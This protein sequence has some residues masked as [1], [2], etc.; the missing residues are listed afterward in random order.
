MTSQRLRMVKKILPDGSPCPKCLEV[1]RRLR[2]EGL[3]GKIDEVLWADERDPESEGMRLARQH[4]ITRAPFFIVEDEGRPARLYT[5][6]LK[7][8][9]EVLSQNT[10]EVGTAREL[11]R[12]DQN[13]DLL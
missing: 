7:F 1:E 13:L 4:Q 6:Y 11:L 5:S 10:S 12:N 3:L 8:A 2:D 9:R